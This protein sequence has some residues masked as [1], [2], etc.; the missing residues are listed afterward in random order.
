[1]VKVKVEVKVTVKVKVKVLV[2]VLSLSA[3]GFAACATLR[4]LMVRGK[5]MVWLNA[6]TKIM[7]PMDVVWSL[8]VSLYCHGHGHDRVVVEVMFKFWEIK[9]DEGGLTPFS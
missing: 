3:N 7:S 4:T 2:K 9:I 1:M 5:V 6:L 8:K